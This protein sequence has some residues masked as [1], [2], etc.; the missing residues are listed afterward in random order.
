MSL[1]LEG[2]I[3]CSSKSFWDVPRVSCMAGKAG[4]LLS[5]S[6]AAFALPDAPCMQEELEGSAC[7]PQSLLLSEAEPRDPHDAACM[8]PPPVQPI[9]PWDWI[10]LCLEDSIPLPFCPP[11]AS[12]ASPTGQPGHIVQ[13][14]FPPPGAGSRRDEPSTDLAGKSLAADCFP[15]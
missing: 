2:C 14:Q 12:P 13:A 8:L 10:L 9:C 4:E 15:R 11:A 6:L 7:A 1:K 3:F 5:P